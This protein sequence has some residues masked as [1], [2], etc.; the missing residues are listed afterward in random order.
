MDRDGK[1]NHQFFS[2]ARWQSTLRG[3]RSSYQCALLLV[4][5]V[6]LLALNPEE[7]GE[8]WAEIARLMNARDYDTAI[9]K[10]QE[11]MQSSSEPEHLAEIYYRIGDIYN[12][13]IHNYDKALDAYQKVVN[14]G[15]KVKSLQELEPYLPLS[16]MKIAGILRRA[17]RYDD[18][19]HERPQPACFDHMGK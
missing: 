12:E 16:R 4:T 14:L 3:F 6:F 17:G 15:K 2:R 5:A 1:L 8:P 18:A 9:G 10:L 13:Y 7:L 11:Y 19:V